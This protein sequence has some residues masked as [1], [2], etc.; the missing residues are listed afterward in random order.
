MWIFG[1]KADV[2]HGIRV[3]KNPE[4]SPEGFPT[5]NNQA[6]CFRFLRQ[7]RAETGGE[8]RVSALPPKADIRRH[9]RH[10]R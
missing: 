7:P 4:L 1:G 8:E 10:V 5:T 6:A 3:N 2:T 9:D